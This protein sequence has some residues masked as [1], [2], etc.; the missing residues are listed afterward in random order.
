MDVIN[1]LPLQALSLSH[2]GSSM[3]LL[4][5]WSSQHYAAPLRMLQF[6][7]APSYF[8]SAIV[9]SS[10]LKSSQCYNVVTI[11]ANFCSSLTLLIV[12]ILNIFRKQTHNELILS[13]NPALWRKTILW[14][15][16]E[17]MIFFTFDD[18]INFANF[19]ISYYKHQ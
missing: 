3:L 13:F 6:F 14:W 4:S 9:P 5:T 10:R 1:I 2:S 7:S 19:K 11:P 16:F 8:T 15:C 17:D 18:D 12:Q